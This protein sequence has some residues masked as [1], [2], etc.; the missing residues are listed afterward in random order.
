MKGVLAVD[1]KAIRIFSACLGASMLLTTSLIGSA[2]AQ[3]GTAAAA[4]YP[5]RVEICDGTPNAGTVEVKDGALVMTPNEGAEL[6]TK[7]VNATDFTAAEDV[8]ITF[9]Y[10]PEY[11]W[12][13][14]F[15]AGVGG[16][17][18]RQWGSVRLYVEGDSGRI[19]LKALNDWGD[20]IVS[21]ESAMISGET[22]RFRIKVDKAA[23]T[24]SAW[25]TKSGETETAQPQLTVTD[26]T[27]KKSCT[28][29]AKGDHDHSNPPESMI[30]TLSGGLNFRASYKTATVSSLKIT[31]GDKTLVEDFMPPAPPES[32]DS[33]VESS[34][35]S[36][37][38]SDSSTES[39]GSSTESEAEP[40]LPEEKSTVTLDFD[41]SL[42][43]AH[44]A[45]DKSSKTEDGN[46]KMENG[47]FHLTCGTRNS[48]WS[49]VIN[50]NLFTASQDVEI[51]FDYE[52][53]KRDWAADTICIGAKGDKQWGGFVLELPN[54][55]EGTKMVELKDEMLQRI[56]DGGNLPLIEG[57]LYHFRITL[58]KSTGTLK[59]WIT[60][61]G[62][63]E[64]KDPVLS[65]T[66][67]KFKTLS[68]GVAFGG[69][70]SD[71]TVDNLKI[72]A[73]CKVLI[74]ADFSTE[75]TE[76][77]HKDNQGSG[78]AFISGGVLHVNGWNPEH[79]AGSDAITKGMLGVSDMTSFDLSLEYTP[80]EVAWSHDRILLGYGNN[81]GDNGTL[82]LEMFGEG[83]K[84]RLKKKVDG[85]ETVLA[86]ADMTYTANTTYEIHVSVNALAGKAA[87]SIAPVGGTAVELNVKDAFIK[88][89][90]GD[91]GFS[92]W[93]GNYMVD[94]MTV[95]AY[96]IVL[97]GS[98]ASK[99]GDSSDG[100]HGS[101]DTGVALPM[102]AIVLLFGAAAVLLLLNW[103]SKRVHN[104]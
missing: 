17:S 44:V 88:T 87:V 59:V 96:G 57:T 36:T 89:L 40:S 46:V 100:S 70:S 103:K 104:G 61:S 75:A 38:S 34:D 65:Y 67:D 83:K 51:S 11:M 19:D 7:N 9:D 3:A 37:E 62:K 12:A 8:E 25:V 97:P 69:W 32:T 98:D 52:S 53:P 74:N 22:Y 20:T 68:G 30:S 73:G 54:T 66:D 91:I 23:K 101:V 50:A 77:G 76:A 90:K 4:A 27:Y 49:D 81:G 93:G 43:V 10:T 13:P 79:T 60:E 85:Q 2:G 29:C 33:S 78:T 18:D 45:L 94:N 58:T 80:T 72:T 47:K 102:F 5:A 84:L 15:S 24:L 55:S 6:Y 41:G 86:E 1:K 14:L 95:T 31:A 63:K 82:T 48:I 21:V 26:E 92:S 56:A 71:Y 42:K 28:D 16:G 64:A 99:P 39:G 35:S